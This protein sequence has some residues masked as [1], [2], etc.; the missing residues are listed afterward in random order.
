MTSHQ[1][2]AP[3]SFADRFHVESRLG[4]GGMGDVYKAYD[5]VLQRTVAV[6]TLT[7]GQA[8]PEAVERLQREARACAR[9]A[10]PDIVTIHDVLQ[11]DGS[12]CIVMEHLEGGS[13]EALHQFPRFCTLEAK[14]GI[15]IAILGALHYAHGKGVVHRDVKP[16]NVQLLPDGS[17]KVLDFG[18]AHVAGAETLTVTGTMTGT[19]HY[20]SPEQLRA[21]DTD[22]GTDIYSTGI[23][24]YEI[25]TGRRP[26]EGDSV[27]AVLTKVL[28]EPVPAMGT[29]WSE[30]LPEIERIV[31]KAAAK[32]R[33]DR[34]A[35]AED[36]KNALT[37]F[38][39]ASREALAREAAAAVSTPGRVVVEAS[40]ARLP[41]E[42]ATGATGGRGGSPVTAATDLGPAAGNELG[43]QSAAS[44]F[45]VEPAPV[46]GTGADPG[47]VAAEGSRWLRGRLAI[48][49]AAAFAAFIG[50]ILIVYS[51]SSSGSP[52]GLPA[53]DG[54]RT[55]AAPQ[56][57]FPPAGTAAAGAP[58]PDAPGR[59][60]SEAMP[61][62]EA[63]AAGTPTTEARRTGGLASPEATTAGGAGGRDSGT[64][65]G[66][67]AAPPAAADAAIAPAGTP[68]RPGE[69]APAPDPDDG[70]KLLYYSPAPAGGTAVPAGSA[71]IPPAAVSGAGVVNAGIR[72][73]VLR[74]GSNGD[75][76]EV[77]PDT[78]FAS[79]DRIRFV[80]EPNVDGFL[81]VV[82]RG[83][84]G[85]W[86]ML[87]PHPQIKGGRNAV[88][89]FADVTI[90]PEGWFRFDDNPG[91]EQVFVYLSKEPVDTL[92][93]G[94]RPVVTAQTVEP[95]TVIELANSVRSRDL[96]FESED[97]D[98][99]T[100]AGLAAYVVN[101][102]GVGGPVAWTVELHHR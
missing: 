75:A 19:V 77:A 11:V 80:F 73:R 23:L 15:L 32:R 62:G 88:T 87:L 95:P 2:D 65:A 66:A 37:A 92:P 63:E 91:T 78:T 52:D 1:N 40:G 28:Q 86:S 22:A 43:L 26:F 4:R 60:A 58:A 55:S 16:R 56:G 29:T 9:L 79:G 72:Y 30:T 48:G 5:T 20:A 68:A 71:G 33:A 13:L 45:S 41:S 49:G 42:A 81:Y 39:A 99:D 67:P 74:R 44:E 97:A 90:P 101:Q 8:D 59:L 64:R 50:V 70:A 38:L 21:E 46:A 24:A 76:V 61:P 7:P 57:G 12:V 6:K 93:G 34:Y 102:D 89:R 18:V 36:M 69:T 98:A 35:S 3:R 94:A 14:I 31:Q 85:R 83:S 84:T 51:W 10:H 53:A 96:V 54:A 82:Q 17:I 25:L 47:L 100:G 27:A